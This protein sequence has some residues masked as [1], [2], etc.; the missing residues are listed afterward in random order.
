MAT[1]GG[2]AFLTF[3]IR[4]L[5]SGLLAIINIS[6]IEN[7]F[8][9]LEIFIMAKSPI[10]SGRIKKVKKADPP[11]SG[12]S[13]PTTESVFNFE[14]YLVWFGNHSQLKNGFSQRELVRFF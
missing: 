11:I 5:N 8:I 7:I 12:H 14:H 13:L 10:F 3:L 2:S 9:I 1:Y 4:P 6:K